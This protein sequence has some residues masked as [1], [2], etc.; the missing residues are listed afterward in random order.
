MKR[1]YDSVYKFHSHVA[2]LHMLLFLI[3]F[4]MQSLICGKSGV[5]NKRSIGFTVESTCCLTWIW[6]CCNLLWIRSH[7]ASK[8]VAAPGVFNPD[9]KGMYAKWDPWL[10]RRDHTVFFQPNAGAS[11]C[12]KGLDRQHNCI[13]FLSM[14]LWFLNCSVLSDGWSA[15]I[16]FKT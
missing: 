6:L 1:C 5:F 12:K 9:V 15:I 10:W 7:P 11:V 4:F 3:E 16:G 14:L 2:Y 8:G 13:Y